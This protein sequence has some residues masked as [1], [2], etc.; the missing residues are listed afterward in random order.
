V[1]IFVWIG[2]R[3]LG[4]SEVNCVLVARHDGVDR[5]ILPCAAT[6]EAK[7]VFVIGERA[8]NV[9]REKLRRD[10]T[11]NGPSLAQPLHDQSQDCRAKRARW[12][13]PPSSLVPKMTVRPPDG[14]AVSR[15]SMGVSR[16]FRTTLARMGALLCSQRLTAQY[17]TCETWRSFRRFATF[18]RS[19]T[20]MATGY[21]LSIVQNAAKV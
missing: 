11:D 5:W 7:L 8:G 13:F 18:H 19:R 10:L 6:L 9:R 1:V 15:V 16:R 3:R 14:K 12:R 2:C 21:W 4:A 20:N 17:D